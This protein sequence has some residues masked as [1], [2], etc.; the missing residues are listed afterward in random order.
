MG[1]KLLVQVFIDDC[2]TI[3][4][5]FFIVFDLNMLLLYYKIDIFSINLT[6]PILTYPSFTMLIIIYREQHENQRFSTNQKSYQLQTPQKLIK[7]IRLA[8]IKQI[9]ELTS[10][11]DLCSKIPFSKIGS[12]TALNSYR[13]FKYT[14]G[15][16]YNA[17]TCTFRSGIAKL[18]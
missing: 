17:K 8:L 5:F 13:N 12:N 4:H 11:E 9:F 18:L 15:T 10:V 16:N 3:F 2:V 6:K 7:I 1:K 14:L